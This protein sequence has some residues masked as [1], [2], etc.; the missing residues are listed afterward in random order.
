MVEKPYY[1]AEG[2]TLWQGDILAILKSMA[3][4]SIS[5]V[6]TSPPY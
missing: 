2:I 1:E 5:M 6:I 3:N 4:E